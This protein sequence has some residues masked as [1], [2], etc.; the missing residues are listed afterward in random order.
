MTLTGGES[1]VAAATYTG[2]AWR[3]T[4]KSLMVGPVMYSW[5]SSGSLPERKCAERLK[6]QSRCAVVDVDLPR[7]ATVDHHQAPGNTNPQKAGYT[8]ITNTCRFHTNFYGHWI[9]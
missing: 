6:A 8:L 7:T 9:K 4:R 2:A 3:R 1:T 5:G